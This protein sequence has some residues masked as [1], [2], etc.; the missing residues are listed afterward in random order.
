MGRMGEGPECILY[1][2][3]MADKNITLTD[4]QKNLLYP[5]SRIKQ[6]SFDDGVALDERLMPHLWTVD[7][8]G[9]EWDTDT[10]Y[11]V[12]VTPTGSDRAIGSTE[13]RIFNDYQ[14]AGNTPPWSTHRNKRFFVN[15]ELSSTMS[16][17]GGNIVD[18]T[19]KKALFQWCDTANRCVSNFGQITEVNC[20]YFYVRGGAAY[21]VITTAGITVTAK[22]YQKY[23][24]TISGVT[25]TLNPIA[26]GSISP[27]V[28]SSKL[29]ASEKDKLASIP[30]LL[31]TLSATL[32]AKTDAAIKTYLGV[33]SFAELKT[34][35]T[36]GNFFRTKYKQSGDNTV[37][38]YPSTHTA[39]GDTL[40][41]VGHSELSHS[42]VVLS[43]YQASGAFTSV[44]YSEVSLADVGNIPKDLGWIN[45]MDLSSSN[46]SFNGY[47]VAGE[48][49][50]SNANYYGGNRLSVRVDPNTGDIVQTL[51]M[52]TGDGLKR[53]YAVRR[54]TGS[55]WGSWNKTS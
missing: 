19:V 10:Y 6:I 15:V 14:N 2:T 18:S 21:N 49:I 9:S 11:P 47:T 5:K 35:F 26:Y 17:W 32:P 37:T 8:K 40:R 38:L 31:A 52:F 28:V 29:T 50:F 44:S 34:K 53:V 45:L 54:R 43:V 7:L 36:A 41:W 12:I 46:T 48:Y 22:V 3:A 24:Y 39:S 42:I 16:W 27:L 51:S 4:E 30:G 33:S 13:I 25:R 23:D 1:L 55:T 20:I